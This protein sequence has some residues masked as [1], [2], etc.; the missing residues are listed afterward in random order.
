M[1]KYKITL[2]NNVYRLIVT[3]IHT[4]Y[5]EHHRNSTHLQSL[6]HSLMILTKYS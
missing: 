4:G 1:Y 6:E 3:V 2:N 5:A